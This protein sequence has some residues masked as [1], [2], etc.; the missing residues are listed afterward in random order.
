MKLVIHF[1]HA[2]RLLVI[3]VGGDVWE[4]WKTALEVYCWGIPY[5]EI[6]AA[7]NEYQPCFNDGSS[8]WKEEFD[9]IANDI[10]NAIT[11]SGMQDHSNILMSYDNLILEDIDVIDTEGLVLEFVHG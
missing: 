8:T 6:R 10:M 3:P 4:M 9:E 2:A 11:S 5:D 1:K 7:I